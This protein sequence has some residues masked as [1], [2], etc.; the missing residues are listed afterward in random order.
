MRVG[1]RPQCI[2]AAM[3]QVVAREPRLTPVGVDNIDGKRMHLY[4][5]HIPVTDTKISET[6]YREM[7]GLPF[8]YRDP[9][10]DIVH[11]DLAAAS[12]CLCRILFRMGKA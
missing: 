6:F 10:R 5:T 3:S 4:E 7:V 2:K 12:Q 11:H 8:A 1:L 9:T